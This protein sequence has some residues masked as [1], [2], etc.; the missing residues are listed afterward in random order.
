MNRREEMERVLS[1]QSDRWSSMSPEQLTAELRELQAYQVE[2]GTQTYQF[3]VELLE[4]TDT[5]I[6]VL[7]AVDDGRIP[8]S[9]TPLTRSFVRQKSEQL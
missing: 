1:A 3:E 6:H 5:Y 2:D 7:V 8:Y 4:N 9:I